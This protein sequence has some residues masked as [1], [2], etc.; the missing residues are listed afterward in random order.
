MTTSSSMTIPSEEDHLKI[1]NDTKKGYL[2]VRAGD[3][4]DI[5]SR[6]E[7]HRGTVQPGMTQTLQTNCGTDNGVV[8]EEEENLRQQYAKLAVERNDARGGGDD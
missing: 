4:V 6:M 5:S 7:M 1:K 8:V 3:G 2:E